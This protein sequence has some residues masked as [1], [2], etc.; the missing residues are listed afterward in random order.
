NFFV[1]GMLPNTTY[2]MRHV[3]S[4]GTGSE[5][6]YFTTGSIPS[7]LT[8]PAFTVLQP[9]GSG[10]DTALDMILHQRPRTTPNSPSLFA[11][12]LAR[13]GTWYCDRSQSGFALDKGGQH[14]IPGGTLLVNG[15]DQYTP[16]PTAPNVLREIDLAGNPIRETNL[17]VVN[18]QLA[19]RGY[20]PV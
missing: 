7:T 9:P 20:E 15:V 18:A 11:T 1:A 10:S 2:Q 19:A 17:A 14:L 12:N 13:Q 3:F 5:P 8:I 4:D 16:I 6:V